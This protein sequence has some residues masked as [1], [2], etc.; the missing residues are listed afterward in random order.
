GDGCRLC[1]RGVGPARPVCRGP[2]AP[3]LSVEVERS[4]TEAF[5]IDAA[6]LQL[7]QEPEAG[8]QEVVQVVDRQCA[9][10]VGVERCCGAAAQS[11]QERVLEQALPGLLQDTHLAR[12][13]DDVGELVE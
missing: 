10:R 1:A 3:V 9:E 12:S 11:R 2:R 8:S 13:T 5:G 6:T 4:V 7:E